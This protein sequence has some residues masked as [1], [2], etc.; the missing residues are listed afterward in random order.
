VKI[1]VESRGEV[2]RLEVPNGLRLL[3]GLTGNDI[4][5]N[6]A[7]GGV[8]SCQKCRVQV[9][10]G[11]AGVST[12]DRKAFSQRELDEGWRLSCQLRPRTNLSCILPDIESLRALPRVVRRESDL[13]QVRD[14]VLVCDLGSTG[15]VVALGDRRGQALLEAH[16]LN[17]Q[18]RFGADVMTRLKA[19]QERGVA[20]LQQSLVKTLDACLRAL[21]KEEPA[22]YAQAAR[23][24]LFCAGNSALVSF[25][26]AWDTAQL[27]V[28]P[29]QPATRAAAS[30]RFEELGLEVHTLPLLAG[31]VGADTFA[32]LICLLER[33]GDDSSSWMLVDVGTNT[34]IVVATGKEFWLSSA[35]AGPAFE[36]GNITRGMRAEAGAIAHASYAQGV[37][38][39]E[40]IGA[41]RAKGLCGSGLVDVIHESVKA[42]L[43]SA[44]GFV[45]GGRLELTESV[46]LLADDVREFQLA[47]SA[48]RTACDLL[49]QRSGT[50]P[51]T[52]YLAGA[53]AEHLDREAAVATGLLPEG[54]KIEAIGNASL[55]GTLLYAAADSSRRLAW[56][57][58]I[59]ERRRPVELALQDD[60]QDAFIKNLNFG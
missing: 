6:A 12:A 25:L 18:V 23:G 3:E 59:E 20:P 55:K 50:R 1:T 45:P 29:F 35:P 38:R 9:T 2:Q 11:F 51:A 15:V 17:K 47:K 42:G 14:P 52:L 7:C 5:V 39:F 34:E 49:V 22:L 24:G 41:D 40:T 33:L 19:V 27:A 57:K 8:G 10:E 54:M 46:Y 26:H 21:E 30:R 36:G 58:L 4:P 28:A 37:W 43:I 32:G 60:F 31:F 44:D 48:T 13:S 53:F 16:L 56:E